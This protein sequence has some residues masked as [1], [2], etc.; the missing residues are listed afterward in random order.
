MN[1]SLNALAGPLEGMQWPLAESLSIGRDRANDIFLEDHAVSRRHCVVQKQDGAYLLRDLD[2]SNGTCVNGAPV[3]ERRLEPGDRIRVGRTVFCYGP[4]ED[5]QARPLSG[6]T[7]VGKTQVLRVEESIYRRPDVAAPAQSGLQLL[8]RFLTSLG[9]AR[10]PGQLKQYV[11]DSLLSA[12]GAGRGALVT[13]HAGGLACAWLSHPEMRVA[14]EVVRQ[15][16]AHGAALVS[17]EVTGAGDATAVLALPLPGADGPFGLVYLDTNDRRHSFSGDHLQLAAAMAAAAAAPLE[18]MLR[19]ERLEAENLRLQN[20]IHIQHDMA[21]DSPRMR[22]VYAFV[23][24]AAPSHSTVL[25]RGESGT[26]KELVARAIHRNSPRARGPFLA[27]NC[28]ALTESLLESELFGH[29]KGAFTGAVAQ[30]RGRIEEAA[31]GSLFLDE[32][33]ELAPAM[34]AKLLRVIQEREFERVGSARPIK[35]DIR[36]IA[37]THRSLE[38]MVNDGSFRQDLYYRLNVISVTIPPLRERC[39]DIGTLAEHFIQKHGRGI[40]RAVRGLSADAS[41]R[42]RAYA[43]P[44]N[45]RELENA[46]ERALVLGS[47]DLILPDDLP[48]TVAEAGIAPAGADPDFHEQVKQA[49]RQIVLRALEAAG[50]DYNEAARR[51]GLHPSNLY[52]LVRNLEMKSELE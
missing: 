8:I 21:G 52:R 29:E 46:I 45:V 2:S 42:L 26:G 34:Q 40:G 38:S 7:S 20:E 25:I 43:W 11:V 4:L 27:V 28:A 49:K 51:L 9:E 18:S 36:L 1:Y 14:E 50:K 10:G 37:A 48:E 6:G 47:T 15:V 5:N 33:G 3:Q 16:L 22:A 19:I 12:T 17:N 24:K 23:A 32:I 44:G 41:A 35:A 30:K 39:E 13:A 31:G